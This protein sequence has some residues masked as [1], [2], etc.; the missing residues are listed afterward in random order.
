MFTNTHPS[1]LTES[2]ECHSCMWDLAGKDIFPKVFAWR[3][4]H[5]LVLTSQCL[6]IKTPLIMIESVPHL[7]QT[8]HRVTSKESG[9]LFPYMSVG[10]TCEQLLPNR[11]N[12]AKVWDVT[13]EMILFYMA[14]VK[15]IWQV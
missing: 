14:K 8:H 1:V 3:F 6:C 10:G 5:A 11:M 4:S 12:K 2:L 13:P 9:L 15:G 7:R